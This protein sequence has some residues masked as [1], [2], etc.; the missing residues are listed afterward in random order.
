MGWDEIGVVREI[1]AHGGNGLWSKEE[2][3]GLC[4]E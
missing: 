3:R 2:K 1:H 4:T